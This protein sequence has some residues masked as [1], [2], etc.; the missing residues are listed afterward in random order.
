MKTITV[1]FRSVYG[2]SIVYPVCETAKIFA[3]IVGGHS[4][5][6]HALRGIKKLGYKI[7]VQPVS[8]D[9]GE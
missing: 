9:W 6:A 5:P 2:K 8:L 4:L 7:I 3:E 1:C